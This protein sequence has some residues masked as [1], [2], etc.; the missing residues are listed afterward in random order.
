MIINTEWGAC[1]NARH[2]LPL[3]RWDN[4]VDRISINPR[5]QAF[6]KL[7]SGMYLGE[8]ARQIFIHLIDLPPIPETNPPQYYLFG[9][10]SSKTMNTQY[11]FD[12]E[13]LSRI[14][15][16]PTPIA[17]RTL[18]AEEMG[19]IAEKISDLDA[20]IVAW[21]C[22]L[23]TCRSAALS[24]CAVAA[25]LI[26]CEYVQIGGEP[27]S[28]K[29]DGSLGVGVDGSLVEFYPQYEAHMRRS[30]RA[31]V[32]PDVEKLINIGMA[33]DGSGVG[34]ALCALVATKSESR[35]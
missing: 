31:I 15:T 1:D 3:T 30:L 25:T 12:T 8:V 2:V 17:V 22:D 19:F 4:A 9:G 27:G 5:Y 26:Q 24:G 32:G 20:E 28:R 33:K 16:D 13:L 35:R 29:V 23:V 34:A 6:E 21:I 7:V 11:G 18:L 14:K 10:H